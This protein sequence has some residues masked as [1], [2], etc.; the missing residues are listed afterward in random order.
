MLVSFFAAEVGFVDFDYALQLLQ[1]TA[2]SLAE[3][4][5]HKPRGLLRNP[6][7]LRQL[8]GGNPLTSGQKQ[9]HRIEPFVQ[10]D[11]RPLENRACTDGEIELSFVAAV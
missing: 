9:V 5:E 1:L 6:N 11:V 3:T 8:H 7:L 10:W 2:A 4:V